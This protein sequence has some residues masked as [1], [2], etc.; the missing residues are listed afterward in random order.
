MGTCNVDDGTRR[1]QPN[2]SSSSFHRHTE[3]HEKETGDQSARF[4]SVPKEVKNEIIT[5]AAKAAVLGNLPLSFAYQKPGFISFARS[6]VEVGQRFSNA[7]RIDVKKLLPSGHA[8]RDG[9]TR[10]AAEYQES[11]KDHLKGILDIGGGV[12]CDGV[13]VEVSGK[14]YYDFVLNFVEVSRRPVCKGGGKVARLRSKLLFITPHSGPETA[15]D[16]RGTLENR[17]KATTGFHLTDFEQTFTFVTDCAATMPCVFGASVSSSRVP[18]SHRWIGCISHQLNTSMKNA[19]NN[20][21]I[22]SGEIGV[23][24]ERVKKIVTLFKKSAMNVMMPDGCALIQEVETRFGTVHDVSR[25]F[26]KAAPHIRTVLDAHDSDAA[27]K[28]MELFNLLRREETSEEV[29]EYPA[30]KAVV[31]CFAPLRHA[32]TELEANGTPTIMKI[33][34]MLEDMK[35]YLKL[36][37]LGVAQSSDADITHAYTRTLAHATLQSL[38]GIRY[39]DMWAAACVLHPGLS[40]LFFMS[41]IPSEEMRAKG[42]AL[43]RRMIREAQPARPS[44]SESDPSPLHVTLPPVGNYLGERSWSLA[45]KMSF[46]SSP[47]NVDALTMFQSVGTTNAE[48]D[49]LLHDEGILQYWTAKLDDYP[50]L[51]RIALRIFATPASSSASERDFSLFKLI[52]V[53]GR[54]RLKDDILGSL[55]YMRSAL[56]DEI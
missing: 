56:A 2:V 17:I 29:V 41:S 32:Q 28:A 33:L 30:L 18:Y 13:K 31:T 9:V 26:L 1:Y 19:M 51:A 12:T 21:Q 37:S 50:I 42:E 15:Q 27:K 49:M 44:N 39:H 20:S 25:R 53:P 45:N 34:P 36:L 6:L 10:L 46:M 5:A 11:F 52:V 40:S 16:I 48:K 54:N 47:H 7:S 38:E 35:Q 24:F 14:K 55:A 23:D 22:S 8:V 43:V 4:V 3:L